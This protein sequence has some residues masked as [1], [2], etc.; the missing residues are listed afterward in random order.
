MPK[1]KDCIQYQSTLIKAV[2]HKRF[3]RPNVNFLTL[4]DNLIA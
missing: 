1:I 4:K 2:C 3:N